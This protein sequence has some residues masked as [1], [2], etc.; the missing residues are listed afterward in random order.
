MG[1]AKSVAW[2]LVKR[3]AMSKTL[4]QME[5]CYAQIQANKLGIPT[6]SAAEYLSLGMK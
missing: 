3:E 5:S 6:V 1:Y 4:Y 2:Y